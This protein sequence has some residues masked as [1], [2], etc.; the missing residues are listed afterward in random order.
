[1][2]D[3][4]AIL[5]RPPARGTPTA[6]AAA[7]ATAAPAAPS[8]LVVFRGVADLPW[9]RF[10]RPGFRH[11]FVCLNDGRQWLV[12]D[13]LSCRTELATLSVS[14][15]FDLAAWF[16]DHGLITVPARP[17]RQR[18][19]PLPWAPFTCVEAVKRVLGIADPLIITPWQL[20]QAL[21]RQNEPAEP[22]PIPTP[23]LPSH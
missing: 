10:L 19:R 18:R 23:I 3:V 17:Q 20:F 21:R 6:A 5:P 4:E 15:D 8:S 11:C 14:P 2:S 1:M 7:P 9:Q 22:T 16:R 12:L 13:P